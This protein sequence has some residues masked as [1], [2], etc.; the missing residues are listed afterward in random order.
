M[1]FVEYTPKQSCRVWPKE[2]SESE[3]K[4]H[5]LHQERS[6]TSVGLQG[7]NFDGLDVVVHLL[8]HPF[9]VWRR[10]CTR[11]YGL[12]G[13]REIGN[14]TILLQQADGERLPAEE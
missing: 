11:K 2:G 1:Q 8:L 12:L 6:A 13:D 14:S 9:E 5:G 10:H 4:D 7:I 3:G